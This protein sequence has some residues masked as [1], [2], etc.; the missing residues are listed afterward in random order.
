MRKLFTILLI[1][2]FLIKVSAQNEAANWYFGNHAGLNFSEGFPQVLEGSAMNSRAGSASISDKNGQLLFYTNGQT[3][4]N[5]E[6]RIME[7]GDSLGAG[8]IIN[9]NCIIVPMPS[10][11][12]NYYL[13]TVGDQPDTTKG[14]VYSIIDM[15]ADNGMGV[16]I[17]KDSLITHL[18]LLEK[19]TAIY[20][21][22]GDDIWVIIHDSKKSF[23][24]FLID[25]HG[26]HEP[27]ISQTG[28][29]P[30]SDIGYMKVSPASDRI[31][32]PLNNGNILLDVF[33]FNNRSGLV[34]SPIPIYAKDPTTYAYGI[35]FSPDG[36][37]LYVSTGGKS[38]RLWQYNLRLQT[39]DKINASAVLIAEGNNRAMQLAP[40][41]K[42]YIAIENRNYLNS[43]NNP[44][45]KG[46]ACDFQE[47]AI[48]LKSG[49]S[50]MGLP[51]FIQSWFYQPRFETPQHCLGDTNFFV[52]IQPDNIDSLVWNFGDNSLSNI[53]NPVHYYEHEGEY[54][55]VLNLYHCGVSDFARK[56]VTIY[57]KPVVDFGNDTVIC[58]DCDL[59]LDLGTA[60][61]SALWQDGS[62]QN[63]YNVDLSG[64]YSVTAWK[65]G[66]KNADT[67][68]VRK[69]E[70][71]II[72]PNAFTP[73]GDG[74]NDEFKILQN[75][76]I[77]HYNL[78]IFNS[79]GRVIFESQ[80][81]DQGWNGRYQGK[82]CPTGN[83][84]W[85]I[86]ITYHDSET[87]KLIESKKMGTV[88]LLR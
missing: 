17:L 2:T 43:I 33:R 56:Q 13:F 46:S 32:L 21:C 18:G 67:I 9:Q 87:G 81:P 88:M 61:D 26:I 58:S 3:I 59:L 16:V 48:I 69:E 80:S 8:N 1:V 36:N 63:W 49:I 77:I 7:N 6:H 12:N 14:L 30:K 15:E 23:Q 19:I 42:I 71:L 76:G 75:H 47:R 85:Q 44:N 25:K 65:N 45:E 50:Q 35:A 73:N 4:W 39:A 70:V 57:K 40:D 82:N 79:W 37:F 66:C 83:Y 22:N 78:Q 29:S 68:M 84:I 24:S 55:V 31:A 28:D 86:V 38:Y 60:V 27:V 5:R 11:S 41:G 62:H 51:N 54:P 64:I 53:P 10:D 74:L 52:S 20:H 72:L 34:Y